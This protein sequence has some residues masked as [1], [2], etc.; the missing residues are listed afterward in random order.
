MFFVAVGNGSDIHHEHCG[1]VRDVAFSDP[2]KL[3]SSARGSL[4]RRCRADWTPYSG[5]VLNF[6]VWSKSGS[7]RTSAFLSNSILT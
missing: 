1:N 2:S 4:F 3:C 6:L 7:G 5:G